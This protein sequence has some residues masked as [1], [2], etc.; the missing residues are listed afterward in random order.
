MCGV[1]ELA[2]LLKRRAGHRYLSMSW[3]MY[4]INKMI[5]KMV[6]QIVASRHIR[7]FSNIITHYSLF[8]IL[9]EST[10]EYYI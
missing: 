3:D 4:I 7:H 8:I 10:Y 2:S 9:D 5:D 6:Q 1:P